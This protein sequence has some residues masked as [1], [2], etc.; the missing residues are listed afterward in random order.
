MFLF[1]WSD[2]GSKDWWLDKLAEVGKWL[3]VNGFRFIIALIVMLLALKVVNIFTKKLYKRLINSNADKTLS[4]VC[5]NVITKGL[6]VIIVIMFLAYIGIETASISA[7]IASLGVGIGLAMEGA[8]SNLAGGILIIITRPF[9][10]GDY[11]EAQDVSGTVEDIRI[12]Y[13]DIVTTDNVVIKIPNGTLANGVITNKSIKDT[14]RV[15]EVFSVAYGTDL[16]KA[17][18]LIIDVCEAN[19]LVF[20]DPK[21][22][23]RIN[24]HNDSGLDIICRVWCKSSDYWTVHYYLIEEILKVFELN[25]IEIPYNKLDVNITNNDNKE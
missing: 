1:K 11:I 24:K 4:K 17:K 13:T 14:R 12:F 18:A 9:K 21:P 7:L 23:C 15:D 10:L 5:F 16:E 2:L 25:D 20:K 3:A 8:L 19:E 6:K 22:F